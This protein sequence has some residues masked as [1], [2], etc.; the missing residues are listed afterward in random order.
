MKH[1]IFIFKVKVKNLFQKH[2][3]IKNPNLKYRG[4]AYVMVYFLCANV[5]VNTCV[6]NLL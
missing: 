6:L 4:A 5:T 3:K 2:H 1:H